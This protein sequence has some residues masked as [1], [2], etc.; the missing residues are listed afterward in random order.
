MLRDHHEGHVGYQLVA[1]Q[2]LHNGRHTE[3]SVEAVKDEQLEELIKSVDS[4][5]FSMVKEVAGSHSQHRSDA[6]GRKTGL[7]N[8]CAGNTCLLGSV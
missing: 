7:A 3:S 1:H 6:P 2:E 5:F 8:R 4:V